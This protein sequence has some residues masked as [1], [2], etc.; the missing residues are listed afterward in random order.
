[1]ESTDEPNGNGSTSHVEQEII[2]GDASIYILYNIG[3]D[4]D[5][6]REKNY[7]KK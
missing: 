5:F 1:M 2:L 7:I 3:L 4:Y 6:S